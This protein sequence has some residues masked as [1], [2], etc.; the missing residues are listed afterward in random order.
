MARAVSV[1]FIF[2]FRL[3]QSILIA[4]ETS[5]AYLT[6][7]TTLNEKIIDLQSCRFHSDQ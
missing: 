4:T 5:D 3:F 6:L 1:D 7:Q 2:A